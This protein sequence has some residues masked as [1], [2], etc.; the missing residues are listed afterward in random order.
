ML[1]VDH[2]KPYKTGTVTLTVDY[3]YDIHSIVFSGRTFCRIIDRQQ[4]TIKGQSF[5]CEGEREQDYWQLN[6][7]TIGSVHVYTDEGRDV[8][9]GNITD[10]EVTA[11]V[12][13][14]D[15]SFTLSD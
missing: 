4:L 9:I 6:V 11:S 14:D 13:L 5:S 10:G 7:D 2:K 12:I 15:M 8:Y 1:M 3:G